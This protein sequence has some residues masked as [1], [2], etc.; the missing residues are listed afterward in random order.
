MKKAVIAA[1][2]IAGAAVITICGCTNKVV[3]NNDYFSFALTDEQYQQ[4]LDYYEAHDNSDSAKIA[5][6][7]AQSLFHS[8][9]ILSIQTYREESS[10]G[11]NVW[12]RSYTYYDGLAYGSGVIMDIDKTSGD[13]YI[14]TCCHVVYDDTALTSVSNNVYVYL[15]GQDVQDVNY[16]IDYE[17]TTYSTTSYTYYKYTVSDDDQYRMEAT[18]VAASQLYDLAL[19]KI[20]GSDI[21]KNSNATAAKFAT[22]DDSENEYED[23]VT[24]GESVYAIGNNLGEGSS[25]TAGSVSRDS[26]TVSYSVDSNAVYTGTSTSGN[27]VYVYNTHRVIKTSAAVNYGCGGGGL[28]NKDGELIGIIC[29]KSAESGTDNIGYAIPA[30]QVRRV[31]NLMMANASSSGISSTGLTMGFFKGVSFAFNGTNRSYRLFSVSDP[32]YET[33]YSAAYL[34]YLDDSKETFKIS[35]KETVS[36]NSTSYGLQSGDIITH[37]TIMNG[38]ETVEDLDITRAFLLDDALL[39]YQSGYTVT[40]TYTR[41]GVEGTATATCTT[42]KIA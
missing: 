31:Y 13:A 25:V 40:L 36:A 3:E 27:S 41:D 32:G 17:T 24:I 34:E 2:C 37:L 30:G 23:E 22:K 1:A 18:V 15:Y 6:A 7:S 29:D 42:E 5:A 39:S 10:G 16:T 33:T 9:S 35:V 14:L 20:S 8:V 28:Y 38:N 19:L 4:L 21:I 11:P 26:T 12:S